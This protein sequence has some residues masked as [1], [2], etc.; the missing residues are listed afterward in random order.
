VGIEG[1]ETEAREAYEAAQRNNPT[2]PL[3]YF[4]EAQLDLFRGDDGSARTNLEAALA[5]KQNFA[6]A[7]YLLS[8]VHARA[9]DLES[10][11]AHA[12]AVVELVPQ[13]PLGWYNLGTIMYAQKNF[14]DAAFSFERAVGIQNEYADA[15]FLLG[16]S[17]YQLGRKDDALTALRVVSAL[18][19]SDE[20]L[21]DIIEKIEAGEDIGPSLE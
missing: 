21:T 17:Y 16:L 19:P 9:G 6:P 3:P 13:D 2:S 15:L 8:Q 18:N 10:A 14:Q 5:L 7:H 20:A 11:Q 1:A 12:V 4:G